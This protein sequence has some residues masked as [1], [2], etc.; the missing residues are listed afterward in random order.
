VTFLPGEETKVI[1]VPLLNDEVKESAE[2]FEV[3][4]RNLADATAAASATVSINDNDRG[5]SF[6]SDNFF[7]SEAEREVIVTVLRGNDGN[8]PFTV[9]Y[10]TSDGT[11]TAAMDYIA[12]SGTLTFGP[13]ET[14]KTITIPLLDD[15]LVEGDETIKLLLSNPTSGAVLGEPSLAIVTIGITKAGKSFDGVILRHRD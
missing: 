3:I 15:G 9:D 12:Q 13:L 8:F 10:A 6:A 4:A 2:T 14:T 7:V 1:S 11:A 5:V